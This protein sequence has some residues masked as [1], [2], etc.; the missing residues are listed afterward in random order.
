MSAVACS[1]AHPHTAETNAALVTFCH[2]S[3][4]TVGGWGGKNNLHLTS[5]RSSNFQDRTHRTQAQRFLNVLQKTQPGEA[6]GELE[7]SRSSDATGGCTERDA[8]T[9]PC[10]YCLQRAS[11]LRTNMLL[12]HVFLL[13]T[14]SEEISFLLV[15]L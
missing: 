2:V 10:K 1:T 3:H 6:C 5:V 12:L 13:F 4:T 14:R 7:G 15:F 11:Q 8:R 9:P